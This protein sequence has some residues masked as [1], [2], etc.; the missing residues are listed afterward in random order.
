MAAAEL[1]AAPYGMALVF[2]GLASTPWPHG[3][4]TVL[5]TLYV[6]GDRPREF[7]GDTVLMAH[8][9]PQLSEKL[10]LLLAWPFARRGVTTG[11]KR[12]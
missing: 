5:R 10:D 2:C 3:A 7:R 9:A 8:A 12:G 1:D 11:L 4:G 6:G